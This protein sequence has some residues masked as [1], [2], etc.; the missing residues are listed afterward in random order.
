[1]A[2]NDWFKDYGKGKKYGIGTQV[3]IIDDFRRIKFGGNF[4]E[5]VGMIERFL[6]IGIKEDDRDI[7]KLTGNCPIII[8][9]RF[10]FRF[11]IGGFECNWI[12]LEE[13]RKALAN[14]PNNYHHKIE[15]KNG[16]LKIM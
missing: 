14:S 8:I 11:R 12:P 5:R 9:T 10:K 6:T 4:K 15:V 16:K 2:D 1:M 13:A 7:V 3:I